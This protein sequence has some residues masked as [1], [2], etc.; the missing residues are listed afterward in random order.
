[1]NCPKTQID[2]NST[3]LRYAEEVCLKRLPSVVP[4]GRDPIWR[5][6][7]PNSYSDFGGEITT[8]ARNPINPS[9]QRKRGAVVDLEASGG[10]TQDLT[11]FNTADLLQGFLFAD[12]REKP[13]TRPMNGAAG[14][15]I[16]AVATATDSFAAASG[17]AAFAARR[18]VRASGFS[19][20]TNNGVHEV[21]S[22]T[23]TSVTVVT[24][25]VN[26]TAPPA[27]AKLEVVGHRFPVGDL[28]VALNGGLVRLIS[29]AANLNSLGLIPGEWVYVGGDIALSRFVNNRG[30][31]RVS[32][33]SPGFVE[34]DKVDWVAVVEA[35][36]SLSIEMYFGTAIRNEF[37]PQLIKRRSYQL[38][39][40]LGN[41]ADGVMS[42]YLVGAVP[43][44]LTI[45]VP[46][47]EKVTVDMSFMATDHETRTGSE[48]PKVGSR[49]GVIEGDA[50][51]TSSDFSRIKLSTVDDATAN[52][53]PLFAFGTDLSISI[54]NNVSSVKAV[55]VL[56]AFEM[57]TG[58]FEVGGSITAYFADVQAVRAVRNN[59][60]V[61]LDVIMVRDN[62]GIVIDIP[63]L[64]LGNGR[65]NVEQDQSVTLPLDIPAA[66][67]K[68]G[69][70]LLAQ[71]F[72][73]L[74]NA[75]A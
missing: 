8:V 34:F 9:R 44:E 74:P 69:Y 6:L 2:S 37:D 45:N 65:I 16:T 35:G 13:T 4:D 21:V 3:G 47:A 10:F 40:T 50:F 39:R 19:A 55:G 29:V 61:T 48:G 73:Y 62:S 57:T 42:E 17:L 26:E 54:N 58:T 41:D 71:L 68:F 49:V 1:M 70:T 18:L 5:A 63:L 15:A 75:A 28:S 27:G 25:L 72:P 32:A 66:E 20:A 36:G 33:V 24:D 46:Q 51:N 67:G 59:S 53:T 43:S 30:F 60:P 12:A 56:G 38:E 7:E 23:A 14:V 64:S 22:S 31:A 52:V 11:F